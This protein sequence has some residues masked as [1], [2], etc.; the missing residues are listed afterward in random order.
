MVGVPRDRIARTPMASGIDAGAVTTLIATAGL[1]SDDVRVSAVPSAVVVP[2]LGLPPVD[3]AGMAVPPLAQAAM[4]FLSRLPWP[5]QGSAALAAAAPDAWWDGQVRG[6]QARETLHLALSRAAGGARPSIIPRGA[7]AACHA[8]IEPGGHV[9]SCDVGRYG[10]TAALCRC[11]PGVVTLLDVESIADASGQLGGGSFESAVAALAIPADGRLP[12]H[13]LKHALGQAIRGHGRRVRVVLA[14]AAELPR[15]QQTPVFDLSAGQ[16]RLV[17]TAA[18]VSRL[19]A[20]VA[21]SIRGALAGLLGRH[22][23]VRQQV[24]AVHVIGGFGAFAPVR[25]VVAGAVGDGLPPPVVLDPEA[26]VRGALRIAK[27]QVEVR[28][29]EVRSVAVPT[30]RVLGGRL[31]RDRVIVAL[32]GSSSTDEVGVPAQGG[33]RRITLE[34]EDADG[35]PSRAP[36]ETPAMTS[37][38]YRSAWWPAVQGD[39]VI[40]F[41]P[42]GEPAQAVFVPIPRAEPVQE[43]QD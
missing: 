11:E 12:K 42:L 33:P 43:G 1:G 25:D 3:A 32:G 2:L 13:D 20:P 36:I 26:V 10:A 17:L 30:H 14:R 28:C 34:L 39:G 23:A 15:Y 38:V 35:R 6:A 27:G 41:R 7:A 9:L 19:F 29:G 37:G 31:V 18:E 24:A 8:R 40:V 22:R 5:T 21:E 16:H 4:D